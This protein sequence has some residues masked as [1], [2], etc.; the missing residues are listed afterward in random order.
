MFE[1]FNAKSGYH[2]VPGTAVCLTNSTKKR[3]ERGK[4]KNDPTY[5]RMLALNISKKEKSEYVK[6]WKKL[7]REFKTKM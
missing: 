5:E 6:I 1:M 3:K 4:N 7:M 2:L